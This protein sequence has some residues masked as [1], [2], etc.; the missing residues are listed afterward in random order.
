MKQVC[1][2]KKQTF[3]HLSKELYVCTLQDRLDMRRIGRAAKKTKANTTWCI[4]NQVVAIANY[5]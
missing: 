3:D 4:N 2:F 1:M 5:C